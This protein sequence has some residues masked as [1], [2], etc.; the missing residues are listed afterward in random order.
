[1][2]VV[3][4]LQHDIIRNGVRDR[5]SLGVFSTRDAAMAHA[6]TVKDKAGFRDPRGA[7]KLLEAKLGS[8][9]LP[10]GVDGQRDETL[11][12][13]PSHPHI[14][15]DQAFSLYNM[16]AKD[17]PSTDDDYVWLGVF[18]TE[19]DAK[20]AIST[21]SARVPAAGRVFEVH[22]VYLNRGCWSEGFGHG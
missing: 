20:A 13:P 15:R 21:L 2:T 19:F 14:D 8:A 7:F 11:A 1:M 17:D 12:F 6:E 9:Y 18:A 10:G 22:A 3:F 16:N 5:K 4:A